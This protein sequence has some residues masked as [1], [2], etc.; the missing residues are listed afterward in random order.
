MNRKLLHRDG[1]DPDDMA[2]PDQ[3]DILTNLLLHMLLLVHVQIQIIQDVVVVTP[4]HI[5]IQMDGHHRVDPDGKI[6]MVVVEIPERSVGGHH[7]PTPVDHLVDDGTTN[8]IGMIQVD[9][10][11]QDQFGLINLVAL[12]D[13]AISQNELEV[14]EVIGMTIRTADIQITCHLR[15]IHHI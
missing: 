10:R 1:P 3:V 7:H 12:M 13:G 2:H 11:D 15:S 8:Q 4:I 9:F 14:M 5:I 6:H